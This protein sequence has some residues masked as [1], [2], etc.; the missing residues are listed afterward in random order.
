VS[1]R[2]ER[3]DA[4][5]VVVLVAEEEIELPHRLGLGGGARDE[6]VV[7]ARW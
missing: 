5:R 7:R 4:G 2:A 6:R 3:L 1:R